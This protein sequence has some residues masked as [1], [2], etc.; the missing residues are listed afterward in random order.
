[1]PKDIIVAVEARYPGDWPE[2]TFEDA[3]RAVEMAES[4]YRRAFSAILS[5]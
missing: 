1:M 3:T 5:A 2:A 4:I